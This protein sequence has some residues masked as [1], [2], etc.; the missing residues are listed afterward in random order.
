MPL[1]L[2]PP[3]EPNHPFFGRTTVYFPGSKP[4]T[5]GGS[6]GD[7]REEPLPQPPPRRLSRRQRLKLRRRKAR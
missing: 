3:L 1:K 4:S 6:E 5:T 2:G 7:K